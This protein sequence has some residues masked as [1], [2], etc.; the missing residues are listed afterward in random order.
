MVRGAP[1]ATLIGGH[2]LYKVDTDADRPSIIISARHLGTKQVMPLWLAGTVLWRSHP[3]P[4]PTASVSP[5]LLLPAAWWG[6][7]PEGVRPPPGGP[8]PHQEEV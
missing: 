4:P 6:K 1:K 2:S 7:T 8:A 3:A 5:A